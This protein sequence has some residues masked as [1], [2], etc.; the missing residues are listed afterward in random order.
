MIGSRGECTVGA[1]GGAPCDAENRCAPQH[2]CVEG[3]CRLVAL[4][5]EPCGDAVCPYGFWCER[6]ACVPQPI[7]GE[8]CTEASGCA[9]GTC[10]EGRCVA[11]AQG[12]PCEWPDPIALGSCEIG[13]CQ[14]VANA[15][16]I[17]V[18]EGE[19]CDEVA[20]HHW[21]SIDGGWF[22]EGAL[23]CAIDDSGRQVCIRLG[24]MCGG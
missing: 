17:L 20:S 24:A 22:D 11:L 3:T 1:P 7:T 16:P 23:V 8:A 18:G 10:T 15:C 4:P 6:G 14:V 5:G 9:R 13:R 2:R 21:C 12:A 19:E